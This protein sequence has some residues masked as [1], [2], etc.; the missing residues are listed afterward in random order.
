MLHIT[1]GS[2][3]MAG[4]QSINTSTINNEFCQKMI[5]S[6]AVC[7]SCYAKTYEKMRPTLHNALLRN[8]SLMSESIL[9]VQQLPFVNA[10]F[11]RIHSYGELINETHL[12]N[13][14]NFAIKNSHSQIV[15]WT[16]RKNIVSNVLS[17]REKPENLTL[18]FSSPK[19]NQTA[20]RPEHFDKV[21]T[22]FSKD[23]KNADFINCGGK[24]CSD[25]KICYTKNNIEFVN[26]LL[27]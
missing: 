4:I 18:I 20:S 19:I 7:R 21:F 27:K 10:Q 24:S 9:P 14:L 1:N 5:K 23:H 6:D 25:C 26:E 17:K 15:L 13:I 16:K 8:H 12:K 11:M 2:G 3:K 22:V